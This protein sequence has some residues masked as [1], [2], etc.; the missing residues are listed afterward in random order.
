MDRP[1]VS[2]A[3]DSQ[4]RPL[5]AHLQRYPGLQK[6]ILDSFGQVQD[7]EV[8]ALNSPSDSPYNAIGAKKE[9]LGIRQLHIQM[10]DQTALPSEQV[11]F[12]LSRLVQTVRP[13]N[14]QEISVAML[15]S[16]EHSHYEKHFEETHSWKEAFPRLDTIAATWPDL[17][18]I[19]LCIRVVLR[20]KGDRIFGWDV[21]VS[22]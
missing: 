7:C 15:L 4:A 2:E 13:P 1:D 3:H 17:N 18:V 5:H 22:R 9:H 8:F 6:L 10:P 19:K 14:I 16:D 12:L 11:S 21:W 20:S